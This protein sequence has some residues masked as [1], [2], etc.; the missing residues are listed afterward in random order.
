MSQPKKSRQLKLNEALK[1]LFAKAHLIEI[2]PLPIEYNKTA[3]LLQTKFLLVDF[4]F[5]FEASKITHGW[6]EA[7]KGCLALKGYPK[8]CLK[9]KEN[10]A[11][12]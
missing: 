2:L 9:H 7:F 4:I 1:E 12:Y 8:T 11:R 10:Y 5:L 6:R 3:L